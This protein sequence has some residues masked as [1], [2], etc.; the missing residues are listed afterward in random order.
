MLT[1]VKRKKPFAMHWSAWLSILLVIFGLWL[2]L[3]ISALKNTLS[4]IEK[5]YEVAQHDFS[6][7]S[8]P[9]RESLA[10]T[11]PAPQKM[12]S[13]EDHPQMTDRSVLSNEDEVPVIADESSPSDPDMQPVA[14]PVPQKTPEAKVT[15]A[16][17]DPA[18]SSDEGPTDAS[19]SQEAPEAKAPIAAT[20]S[21]P[22][23]DE[24]P[25]DA[26]ASQEAP[27]AKTPIA[28]TDSAPPPMKAQQTLRLP[29]RPLKRKPQ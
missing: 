13:T 19:A 21:A 25:T 7:K 20:D 4:V 17:I 9:P 2:L 10:E 11:E 15:L 1:P 5:R 18:P 12:I 29:K 6:A 26:S 3:E 8:V 14:P 16:A 28:A 27:E 24:G 22:P 23:S